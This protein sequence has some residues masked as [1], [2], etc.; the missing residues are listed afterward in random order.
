MPVGEMCVEAGGL[1][2]RACPRRPGVLA[3]GS[4]GV[5]WATEDQQTGFPLGL[6]GG[7]GPQ[8]RELGHHARRGLRSL[9]LFHTIAIY[10]FLPV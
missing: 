8:G 7:C 10:S 5:S 4:P 6:L 2:G 3:A 1:A 9:L